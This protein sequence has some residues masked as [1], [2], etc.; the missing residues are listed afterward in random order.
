[1]G[2]KLG[3][4]IDYLTVSDAQEAFFVARSSVAL[5]MVVS[6]YLNPREEKTGLFAYHSSR[7]V[8]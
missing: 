6:K 2:D 5:V 7:C 4:S 3:S 1:M 8:L